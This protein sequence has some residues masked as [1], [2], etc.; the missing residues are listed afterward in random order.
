MTAAAAVDR[1]T[2]SELRVG[3]SDAIR[4]GPTGRSDRS[5]HG[6][7]AGAGEDGLSQLANGT[8]ARE[9]ARFWVSVAQ[10]VACYAFLASVALALVGAVLFLIAGALAMPFPAVR[11]LLVAPVA[12]GWLGIGGMAGFAVA[13]IVLYTARHIIEDLCWAFGERRGDPDAFDDAR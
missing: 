5:S 10:G 12:C 2:P 4:F 11:A 9:R 1:G 13:V 6:A 8:L 7:Q 3:M